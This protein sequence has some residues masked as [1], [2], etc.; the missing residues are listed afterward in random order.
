[1]TRCS[2]CDWTPGECVS[3]FS[4]CQ[5]DTGN[6]SSE[7]F[8]IYDKDENPIC[9]ECCKASDEM[10]PV[11]TEQLEL[12]FNADAATFGISTGE[13]Q[14]FHTYVEPTNEDD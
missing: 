5:L 14:E 9:N 4:L 11:D 13:I 6:F 12:P 8:L 10:I 7:N 2:I 1:M 3:D